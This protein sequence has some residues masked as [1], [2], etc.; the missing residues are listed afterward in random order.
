MAASTRTAATPIP[1]CC[2]ARGS[3]PFPPPAAAACIRI[4]R[5]GCASHAKRRVPASC[6]KTSIGRRRKSLFRCGRRPDRVAHERHGLR[7]GATENRDGDQTEANQSEQPFIILM[8]DDTERI[9]HLFTASHAYPC[10]LYTS[11]S[12]R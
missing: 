4:A 9:V 3:P 12:P 11:P 8:L 1:A 7:Q 6:R 5:S 2:A 10:L